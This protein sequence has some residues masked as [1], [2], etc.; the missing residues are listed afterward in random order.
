VVERAFG[1]DVDVA[2][3]ELHGGVSERGRAEIVMIRDVEAS[4]DRTANRD[5]ERIACKRRTGDEA[6]GDESGRP[7]ESLFHVF[8]AVSALSCSIRTRHRSLP[9][10]G[11]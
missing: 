7:K 4:S 8:L 2:R 10:G 5:G 9:P 3:N 11:N 6:G 1:V